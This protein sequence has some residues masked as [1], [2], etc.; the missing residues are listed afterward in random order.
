MSIS[1]A[2]SKAINRSRS[3]L[4]GTGEAAATQTLAEDFSLHVVPLESVMPH[5]R[6][7]GPRVADLAARLLADG[8]LIN[9]PIAVQSGD[10]YIVLDGATRLTAFRHLGYPH[11]VLQVVEIEAQRV[12]LGVWRHI[13]HGIRQEQGHVGGHY[14]AHSG[15]AALRALLERIEGLRLTPCA[16]ERL[17]D[18]AFGGGL[19]AGLMLDNECFVLE[20]TAD[21]WLDVLHRTVE[22]Y[23]E[24]AN[25]E[26]TLTTH[27]DTLAVHYPD[28]AGLV[29]FPKLTITDVFDLV[30]AGETLPAGITRFIIP[31]RILRLN[32]PLDML[33]GDAPLAEKRAWLDD[34]VAERLTYRQVRYY[35]EPVL[36]LDE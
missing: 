14:G 17:H 27:T 35:E 22:T 1:G 4:S 13:I 26:R 3:A 8:R 28:F 24:S 29:I 19:L 2:I 36:L 32:A 20:T 25:V 18:L 30:A 12:Q 33:A 23:G 16:P 9:P 21:D 7:H 6:F 10:R 15:G 31:G 34:L 11:I 5:E